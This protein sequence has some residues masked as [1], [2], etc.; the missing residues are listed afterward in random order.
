M[1]W[2]IARNGKRASCIQ[3]VRGACLVTLRSSFSS[4]TLRPF[5]RRSYKS[6]S[7]FPCKYLSRAQNK[8]GL[9]EGF[10]HGWDA[11]GEG[12]KTPTHRP[13]PQIIA[14]VSSHSWYFCLV[15][16]RALEHL[17]PSLFEWL[18]I[19]C[20]I[21]FLRWCGLVEERFYIIVEMPC[22]QGHLHTLPGLLVP[23]LA[24]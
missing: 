23:C 19:F 7:S 24:R 5:V 6:N 16:R 8:R 15:R 1:P 3:V 14:K 9:Q 18:R 13:W 11:E 22:N 20:P 21:A 17:N 4:W 2:R 12:K 10:C